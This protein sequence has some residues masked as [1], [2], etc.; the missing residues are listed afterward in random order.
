MIPTP[1]ASASLS[2]IVL[3]Y[4]SP[5]RDFS[6]RPILLR[7][8]IPILLRRRRLRD[9]VDDD[10]FLEYVAF[11]NDRTAFCNRLTLGAFL[12]TIDFSA[13]FT[14]VFAALFALAVPCF[15]SWVPFLWIDEAILLPCFVASRLTN[16]LPLFA[17][18]C[19]PLDRISPIP[20]P[21]LRPPP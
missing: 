15:S 1:L 8:D 14:F 12:L 19:K 13:D 9:F 4:N 10:L 7:F 2:G 3:Y 21:T 6:D 20:E 5:N 11:D 16:L 17:T 18:V